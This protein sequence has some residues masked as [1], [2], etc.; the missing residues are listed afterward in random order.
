MANSQRGERSFEAGGRAWVLRYTVNA[1][2]EL[3]D[4]TGEPV[5]VLAAAMSDPARLRLGTMRALLW[6][7]L[8]D[9]QPEIT[10]DAAGDLLDVAGIGPAIAAVGDAFALAFPPVEEKSASRPPQP[11]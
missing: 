3:E 11:N 2:C 5:A 4:V 1:L 10:L 7:G 8:R 9:R 6:A